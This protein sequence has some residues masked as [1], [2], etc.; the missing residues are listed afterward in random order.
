MA[1]KEDNEEADNKREDE[2][3]DTEPMAHGNAECTT[4]DEYE[5]ESD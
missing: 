3:M 4:G 5:R 1:G 2:Q